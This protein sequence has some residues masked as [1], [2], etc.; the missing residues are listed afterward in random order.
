C[1][2]APAQM[3]AVEAFT[4]ESYRQAEAFVDQFAATR[5]VLLDNLPRLGWGQAAPADGAFYVYADLGEALEGFE[6]STAYCAALLEQEGVALVP[7][8][9]FDVVGGRRAVRLSFAAG[10]DAVT[11]AIERIIR[12]QA[13][14]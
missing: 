10:P 6:D 14:R 12:F 1:P 5:A 4:E 9:D 2:P 13:G 8:A 11:E 3:A 7:G